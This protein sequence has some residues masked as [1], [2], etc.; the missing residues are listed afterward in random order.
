M[1]HAF[2]NVFMIYEISFSMITG[3]ELEPVGSGI[4]SPAVP[5][6]KIPT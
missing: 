5:V 6:G 3:L 1:K 4:H 2:Y